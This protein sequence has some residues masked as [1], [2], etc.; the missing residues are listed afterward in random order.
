MCFSHP[1]KDDYGH[2]QLLAKWNL[3]RQDYWRSANTDF[4]NGCAL[5][6]EKIS[7]KYHHNHLQEHRLS[8]LTAL[9]AVERAA[10]P[11][12]HVRPSHTLYNG[13]VQA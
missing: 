1:Q 6:N 5:E 13:R 12:K 2:H 4:S 3:F 8:A 11:Q 9:G 10:T 7:N